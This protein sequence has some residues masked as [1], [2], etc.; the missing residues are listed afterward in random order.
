MPNSAR[1]SISLTAGKEKKLPEWLKPRGLSHTQAAAYTGLA[2]ATF[3]L[4]RRRGRLPAPTLPGKRYDR[5]LLDRA[6]D[7]LSGIA[8]SANP[9]DAWKGRRG[10]G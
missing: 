6:M 9:L 8:A 2:V 5:I 3:D 7:E 4:Y 10:S 1:R